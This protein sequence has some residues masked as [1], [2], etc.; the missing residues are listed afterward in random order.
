MGLISENYFLHHIFLGHYVNK[1]ECLP[2]YLTQPPQSV[3]YQYTNGFLE[4]AEQLEDYDM[5]HLSNIFDWMD[6][7]AI[8][9][10]ARLLSERMHPEAWFTLRQLNNKTEYKSLFGSG[11]NFDVDLE[12]RLLREDRSL[13]YEKLILG[14][15]A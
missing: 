10:I 11:F 13:F 5:I 7:E 9:R 3:H 15:K 12:D 2:R 1:T 6:R 14:R 4:D 8:E